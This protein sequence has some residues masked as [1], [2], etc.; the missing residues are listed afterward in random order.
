MQIL[1]TKLSGHRHAIEVRG[2]RG[3]DVRLGPRETGPTLPHDLAHA[4][5]ESALGIR[6]G[7]WGVTAQGA[8]FEGF[9][10]V[11]PGRHRRSG[12][13]VLQRLAARAEPA[14]L[15]V[16]WAHRA[17]SGQRTSGRGLGPCPLDER[18]LGLAFRALDRA[19]A[20]WAALREGETLVW[21]WGEAEGR[22][23]G[24]ELWPGEQKWRGRAMER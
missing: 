8:T 20:A 11:A 1:F 19:Q 6:E 17:W 4:A 5:V 15:A 22:R 10:P 3:P 9:E 13:R 7:F 2:R 18:Q 16:S 21:E 14:E 12:I 24:G 23:S